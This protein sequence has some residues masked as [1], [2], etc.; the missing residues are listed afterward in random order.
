M[1]NPLNTP[2]EGGPI[3]AYLDAITNENETTNK[4]LKQ[5]SPSDLVQLIIAENQHKN[6]QAI[7]RELKNVQMSGS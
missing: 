3:Q 7:T 4:A 2:S 6:L 5:L 1:S